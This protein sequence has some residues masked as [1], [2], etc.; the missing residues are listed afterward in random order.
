VPDEDW[1]AICP[2]CKK[3]FA[4]NDTFY[5]TVRAG[6]LA[7]KGSLFQRVSGTM[8]FP[9]GDVSVVELTCPHC[10]A[11]SQFKNEELVR[12][13]DVIEL[14]NKERRAPTREN[15]GELKREVKAL[16]SEIED[17][18]AKVMEQRVEILR[19]RNDNDK[20]TED[21]SILSHALQDLMT[22]K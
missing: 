1:G 15:G 16:R 3:R 22:R 5:P 6:E 20:L 4:L 18:V 13:A 12:P 11:R 7:Y 2:K 14:E 19:L 10:E 9:N 17:L 21:N 8:T